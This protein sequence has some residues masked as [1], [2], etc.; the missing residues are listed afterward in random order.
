MPGFL[1]SGYEWFWF[2]CFHLWVPLYDGQG[3]ILSSLRRAFQGHRRHDSSLYACI[4]GYV[5]SNMQI[6]YPISRVDGLSKGFF[7]NAMT[8]LGC[9]IHAFMLGHGAFLYSLL[10]HDTLT[11]KQ[12]SAFSIRRLSLLH[13]THAVHLCFPLAFKIHR[14]QWHY[15]HPVHMGLGYAGMLGFV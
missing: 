4:L 9:F 3:R 13:C 14:T 12:A 15:L 1:G 10:V 2:L 11:I 6:A 7:H 8:L 5:F